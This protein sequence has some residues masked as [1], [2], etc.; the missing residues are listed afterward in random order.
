MFFKN[1]LAKKFE[2]LLEHLENKLEQ[3]GE[4]QKAQKLRHKQFEWQS[5]CPE[6]FETHSNIHFKRQLEADPSLADVLVTEMQSVQKQLQDINRDIWMAER[7]IESVLRDIPAGP[8][9]RALCAC[10]QTQ[11][12]SVAKI[13][14]DLCVA[15]DFHIFE[16]ED[17]PF[18][19]TQC[20]TFSGTSGDCDSSLF[21]I[22]NITIKNWTGDV[23]SSYAAYMD[24]SE[25]S[26]GCKDITITGFNVTNSTS[27]EVVTKYR[28]S[29]VSS[30]HGFTC[31]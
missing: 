24:C 10:R 22:S 1:Y 15:K 16:T 3:E 19:I 27:G 18:S 6:L 29:D 12:Y 9:K 4:W 30:T 7:D 5:Y 26:G 20:T 2:P 31:S 25:A 11:Y 14:Q 13:S 21:E 8:F 17:Y 23:G 28:G